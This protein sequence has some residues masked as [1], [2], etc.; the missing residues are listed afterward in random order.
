MLAF[1]I[2]IPGALALWVG[3]RRSPQAAFLLVYLPTLFLLPEYYRLDLPGV[4]SPTFSQ[5]A[6]LGTAVAFFWNRTPGYRFSPTD[7]LVVAFVLAASLSEYFAGGYKDG[8]NLAWN[9]TTW[10]LLPYLFAKSMVEPLDLR[11]RFAKTIVVL[12]AVVAVISVYEFRFGTTPWRM[13]FDHFFP[14][15]GRGW[16]T[17][18]RW[19]FARTAGPYGHAILAGILMVVAFRLNRW[20]QWSRAWAPRSRLAPW[21]PIDQGTL[22]SL[23]LAA[24]VIMTM[25]RGPWIGA[26]LAMLVVIIGRSSY[27]GLAI[28]GVIGGGLLI[29][30]PIALWFLDYVSVG[31]VG[32]MTVAQESAAYRWELLSAYADIAAEKRWFGWGLTAWP[33]VPG[34]PSI[35]NYYLLL[36]LMHGQLGL[37]LFVAI[38]GS[39]L[40]RLLRRGLAEPMAD[41]AGSSLSFTLASLFVVYII[42]VAT[43]YLGLQAIP[44]LF[45]LAGWAEGFLRQPATVSAAA[46]QAHRV[47]AGHG[48]R[49]VLA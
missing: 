19:G 32:A 42:S 12:L 41:P 22:L 9:M 16:I 45:L 7:L 48:F 25:V 15:G 14:W 26:V 10:A 37:G 13:I 20:L 46:A 23:V 35:D 28:A 18:F 43:V 49:R 27:R 30:I 39:L 4:P 6:A 21:L 24:G 33:Q 47:P 5:A 11:I 40:V 8:Q 34:M 38:I 1:I 17:T 3:M 44:M 31:R 2:L 29:G 36:L